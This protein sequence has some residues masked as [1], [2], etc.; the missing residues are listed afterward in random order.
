MLGPIHQMIISWGLVYE[1]FNMDHTYAGVQSTHI[2]FGQTPPARCCCMYEY[3]ANLYFENLF[4]VKWCDNLYSHWFWPC[5]TSTL[6]LYVRVKCRS[7][8]SQ[9]VCGEMMWF[10]CTHI[11]SG[12]VPPA[13]S[14]PC[15]AYGTAGP[16]TCPSEP[17]TATA[18]WVRWCSHTAMSVIDN[19][20]HWI[21]SDK[22]NRC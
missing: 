4:V 12:R 19:F 10:V 2:V 9:V 21:S 13:H 15:P 7:L 1:P 17:E 22:V 18:T 8:L 3:N 14:G 11:V 5:P 16:G 6:L 20:I